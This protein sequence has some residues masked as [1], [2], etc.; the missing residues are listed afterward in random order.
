MR[1]LFYSVMDKLGWV[2]ATIMGLLMIGFIGSAFETFP[3]VVGHLFKGE[4]ISSPTAGAVL[5]LAGFFSCF[6][7]VT[8]ER[9]GESLTRRA[10][11]T[12][13]MLSLCILSSL[14]VAAL[15]AY[16]NVDWH[17]TNRLG[18]VLS[19]APRVLV[20]LFLW[21][22][23]VVAPMWSSHIFAESERLSGLEAV[24]NTQR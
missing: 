17:S 16:W 9:R 8:N 18:A 23:V 20:T 15:A 24:R 12:G 13:V 10:S 5:V 7:I 19:G 3:Q 21:I 2:Y 4:S 14:A 11:G 22:L 1:N 6:V